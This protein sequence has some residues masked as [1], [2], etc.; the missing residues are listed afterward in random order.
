M[1]NNVD[2]KKV[3]LVATEGN[4]PPL[5]QFLASPASTS[6]HLPNEDEAGADCDTD[7]DGDDNDIDNNID[8]DE[9]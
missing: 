8:N 2:D 9:N 6:N 1:K 3:G 4:F 5:A 7:E